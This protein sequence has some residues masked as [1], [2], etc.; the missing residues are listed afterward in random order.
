MCLIIVR[1][2]LLFYGIG[3][4]RACISD[5]E[6]KQYLL[7]SLSSSTWMYFSF[8]LVV[9]ICMSTCV[10]WVS[11]YACACPLR[12]L[13]TLHLACYLNCMCVR[14]CIFATLCVWLYDC[15]FVYWIGS[16]KVAIL[17]NKAST[18]TYYISG[19]LYKVM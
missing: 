8:S 7:L 12:R 1:F 17:I 10:C 13:G 5:F 16:F 6:K 9:Y 18:Y 15:W 4:L 19:F 11:M 3:S 2:A 14:A